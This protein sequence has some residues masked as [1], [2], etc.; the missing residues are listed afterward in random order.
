MSVRRTEGSDSGYW[1]TPDTQNHRDGSK[2]RKDNN[3]AQGGR[4]GVSLHHAVW[5]WPTPTAFD[6]VQMKLDETPEHWE[7]QRDKHKKEG[8]NKHFPLTVAVK[9]RPTPTVQDSPQDTGQ[10]NPT[11]VEWLMGWPIG[12]TGLA[13]LETA[14]FQRW[15][16]LHGRC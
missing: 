9:M 10:L 16:R 7:E 14:K 3:L 12:W 11:W 2:L 1:P 8:Q 15:Q 13:P 5:M 6:A 4:H